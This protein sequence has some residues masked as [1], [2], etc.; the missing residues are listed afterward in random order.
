MQCLPSS[1]L[2]SKSSR[3]SQLQARELPFVNH[4]ASIPFLLTFEYRLPS[5]CRDTLSTQAFRRSRSKLIQTTSNQ[6]L[7][8]IPKATATSRSSKATRPLG[9]ASELST[10]GKRTSVT[11]WSTSMTST[12]IGRTIACLLR[13]ERS[14]LCQKLTSSTS[15]NLSLSLV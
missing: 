4:P 1:L 3:R 12:V 8:S 7:A 6:S 13:P 5:T 9:I 11:S 14:S 2:S 15:R 10:I